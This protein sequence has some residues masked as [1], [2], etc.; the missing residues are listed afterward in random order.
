M[1]LLQFIGYKYQVETRTAF[2]YPF[3]RSTMPQISTCLL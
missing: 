3:A 1:Q 2:L